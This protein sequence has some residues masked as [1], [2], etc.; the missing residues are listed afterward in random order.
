MFR[1]RFLNKKKIVGV[2]ALITA[3]SL[4]TMGYSVVLA[5]ENDVESKTEYKIEKNIQKMNLLLGH[6]GGKHHKP[7]LDMD[8]IKDKIQAAV[9]DGKLTQEEA[10][11]KLLHMKERSKKEHHLFINK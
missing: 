1:N 2:L 3:V 9:E 6:I 8:K 4:G 7:H 5:D 11:Q 10:D